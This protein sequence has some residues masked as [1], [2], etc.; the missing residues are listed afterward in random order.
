MNWRSAVDDNVCRVEVNGRWWTID[1]LIARFERDLPTICEA[2]VPSHRTS[3]GRRGLGRSFAHIAAQYR[4]GVVDHRPEGWIP[5]L[6]SRSATAWTTSPH[7]LTCP[8]APDLERRLAVTER[9]LV[10]WEFDEVA[11]EVMLEEL[12]TAFELTLRR[13]AFGRYKRKG[14]FSELVNIVEAMPKGLFDQH[15]VHV[16]NGTLRGE[17]RTDTTTR[18]LLLGLQAARN[19]ARHSASDTAKAWLMSW[20]WAA[21]EVLEDLA[22]RAWTA[23]P[24]A[25]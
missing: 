8:K 14:S 16:I 18:D 25:P 24:I 3:Q 5:R 17:L 19:P 6:T 9:M 20:R 10:D 13:V 7:I 12:A 21:A 1:L 4:F 15:T 2:V 22:L 11:P 23:E